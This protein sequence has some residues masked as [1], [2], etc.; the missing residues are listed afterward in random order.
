MSLARLVILPSSFPGAGSAAAER[1]EAARIQVARNPHGRVVTED[2]LVTLVRGADAAIAGLDPF[3]RRVFEAADRL[4]LLVKYGSGMDSIDLQA[5]AARRVAVRS[6]PGANAVS[7]A[8]H[9]LALILAL[10]RRLPEAMGQD[11]VRP[12]GRELC[13]HTLGV[14]GAGMVGQRVVALGQAVGMRTLVYDER[15]VPGGARSLTELLAEADVVSLHVP[16]QERTYHLIDAPALAG[17]RPG[18]ILINTARGGL[19]DEDAVAQRLDDGS[20]FGVGVDELEHRPGP[21]M[22]HPRVLFTPHIAA[23]TR[24]SAERMAQACVD[25]VLDFFADRG[26]THQEARDSS[27]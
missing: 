22:H 24:E 11:R 20:L 17:M 18:A 1:L 9:T 12:V 6:T 21:L 5:A 7:V 25:H 19:L 15:A 10:A 16:L 8:E 3:T 14:V 23:R 2:E 26:R 27:A 13:G 4:T